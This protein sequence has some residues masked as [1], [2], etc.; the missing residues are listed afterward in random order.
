MMETFIRDFGPYWT[1]A[2]DLSATHSWCKSTIPTNPKG[3][4]FHWELVS[5]EAV[6]VQWTQMKWIM[7][8]KPIWDY[9]RFLTWH[10]SSNTKKYIVYTSLCIEGA[11]KSHI[12]LQSHSPC[13]FEGSQ[14][15]ICVCVLTLYW[16]SLGNLA[17]WIK[18]C[19]F[20]CAYSLV[21]YWLACIVI[22]QDPSIL[23]WTISLKLT[24][25]NW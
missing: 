5:V 7:L 4:L 18:L 25:Y 3:A 24:T 9:L 11:L 8:M 23:K 21:N 16:D 15:S 2:A 14:S 13:L 22:T 10:M 19:G 6:Y 1:V 20:Q 12:S 17:T